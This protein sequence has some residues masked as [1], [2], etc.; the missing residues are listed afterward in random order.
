MDTNHPM[1]KR[2]K[3]NSS[4]VQHIRGDV[5]LGDVDSMMS[6]SPLTP[7]WSMLSAFDYYLA[8]PR[9]PFFDIPFPMFCTLYAIRLR[10]AY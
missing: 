4:A 9:L 7:C 8:R 5:H 10:A 1:L 2:H 6:G 3:L